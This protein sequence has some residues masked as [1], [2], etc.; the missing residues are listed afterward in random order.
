MFPYHQDHST[1]LYIRGS[2]TTSESA[3][4]LQEWARGEAQL[5]VRRRGKIH[6]SPSEGEEE[7]SILHS[8]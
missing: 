8:P 1:Y 3:F 4:I 2:H 7:F 6:S 5:V